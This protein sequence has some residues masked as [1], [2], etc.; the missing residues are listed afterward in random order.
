[1]GESST[2]LGSLSY[3][4][5]KKALSLGEGGLS[6]ADLTGHP[7]HSLLLQAV[8]Q[9]GLVV[10]LVLISAVYLGCTENSNEQQGCNSACPKEQK[11]LLQEQNPCSVS[12]CS[13]QAARHF[14]EL[15]IFWTLGLP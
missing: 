3:A 13:S 9:L 5:A 2:L 15:S 11:S 6:C 7:G 4:A 8:K 10:L 14:P 12:A 1:M